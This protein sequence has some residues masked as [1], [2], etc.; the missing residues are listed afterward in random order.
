MRIILDTGV[1]FRPSLLAGL[2]TRTEIVVVPAIVLAERR[3]QLESAGRESALLW[4][5]VQDAQF[6]I[7]PFGFDESLKMAILDDA[8]WARHARD[9]M[10]AAHVRDGDVLWTTDPRDFLS[11]GLRSEQVRGV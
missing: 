6:V 3:R 9:A 5:T 11:L 4:K 7:E 2:A 1:F 10:I 8:S